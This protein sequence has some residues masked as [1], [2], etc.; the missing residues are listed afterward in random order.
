MVPAQLAHHRLHLRRRLMRAPVR[1]ARPVLQTGQALVGI[2]TQPG[3]QTLPRHP[4]LLGY[5]GHRITGQHRHDGLI[6]LLHDR[7]SHQR[8]SRPPDPVLPANNTR[9][10]NRTV[11]MSSIWWDASVKHVP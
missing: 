3:M 7:H 9:S 5:L 4:D 8:Q 2:A 10:R 11:I 1:A 6:P